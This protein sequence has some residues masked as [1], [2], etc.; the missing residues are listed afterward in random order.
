MQFMT[1]S[2]FFTLF[3]AMLSVMP[4]VNTLPIE[5]VQRDVYVPP[6]LYPDANAVWKVGT[7]HNV[8]WCV[9]WLNWKCAPSFTMNI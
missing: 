8:A 3:F 9:F 4:L 5:L 2:F 1:A 7:K 6:V